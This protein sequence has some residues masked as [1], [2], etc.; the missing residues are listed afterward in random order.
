M[1]EQDM[2]KPAAKNT[3]SRLSLFMPMAG[4]ETERLTLRPMTVMDVDVILEMDMDPEVMKYFP[5]MPIDADQHAANFIEDIENEE[6][7][8]FFYLIVNKENN[9][10][11][12]WIFI[13]PTEDGQ[14]IELG[15]RLCRKFW[16]QGVVPEAAKA[17][18]N[19]A[20]KVWQSHAILALIDPQNTPSCR[21]AEK[22]GLKIV[23]EGQYYGSLHKMHAIRNPYTV[24]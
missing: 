15:Y 19:Y 20:F 17:M 4:L 22:L 23:G 6:R 9:R 3:Y 10:G 1:K 7:Y 24:S 21:V 18:L 2:I 16:G 13:R 11:M 12:G 5:E 8:K 14:W